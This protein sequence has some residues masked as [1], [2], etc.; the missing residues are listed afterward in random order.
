MNKIYETSLLLDFYGQLLTDRQYEI[1]DL[2]YNN[3]FTLT[4]IAE[5]LNISR[6]G[7]YD[8]EK[9]GRAQLIEYENKLGLLDK[10]SLQKQK[11]QNVQET[12]QKL[13]IDELSGENKDIIKNVVTQIEELVN[14]I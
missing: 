10:F 12:M 5:Q 8:N 2:H 7:V 1:L 4:E 3:D 6:Q 14:N 11:A 13:K 9:R